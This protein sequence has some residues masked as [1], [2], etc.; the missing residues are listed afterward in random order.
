MLDESVL[1]ETAPEVDLEDD[2]E[3][4][5]LSGALRDLKADPQALTGIKPVNLEFIQSLPDSKRIPL[6]AMVTHTSFQD[7]TDFRS[8]MVHVLECMQQYPN[9]GLTQR[10]L[11][12]IFS[13]GRGSIFWQIRR[14]TIT[15]HQNGRPKLLTPDAYAMVV[16]LINESFR[17]KDPA[18]LSFLIDQVEIQFGIGISAD[19]MAHIIHRMPECKI[20]DGVPMDKKRIMADPQAIEAYCRELAK[21]IK[22]VPSGLIMNMDETGCADFVDKRKEKVVVP[23]SYP[24]AEVQIPADRTMKRATLVGAIAGDG[25]A[26]TPVIIL[27]R[28]TLEYDLARWG[29][30]EGRMFFRYQENGYI[31]TT[32]FESW[33]QDVLVPYVQCKRLVLSMER[34]AQYEGWAVL[35]LDGCRCHNTAGVEDLLRREKIRLFPL[36]P[37][38]SDQLQPLDLGIYGI[39]KRYF[40][41]RLSLRV[42]N[43]QVAEVIRM[44]DA[45]QSATVAHNVVTAFQA[46]GLVTYQ[47]PGDREWYLKF[48]KE[49]A[50][51]VR[52]WQQ[53][54]MEPIPPGTAVLQELPRNVRPRRIR[55]K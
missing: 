50:K 3:P 29:Y 38:T 14:I 44:C 51:K 20:I 32:R 11:A 22:D 39:F 46:A 55:L 49:E 9:I 6:L 18:T 42:T 7:C 8:Q 54:E 17:T 36:P 19:T 30:R 45:W 12:T 35:L 47:K 31:T 53:P 23:A 41:K 52:H 37:H 40:M 25:S 28:K 21:I 13:V 15:P 5:D 16:A 24:H 48:V 10:D 2:G 34:G 43:R 4:N 1:P 26:L 33:I 27:S